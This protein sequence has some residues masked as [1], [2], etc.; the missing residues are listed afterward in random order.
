MK[1][2]LI[3]SDVDHYQHLEQDLD[4]M[5]FATKFT[6]LGMLNRCQPVSAPLTPPEV[7][8]V[9]VKLK[10]GDFWELAGY[11]TFA[12]PAASIEKVRPLL[13]AAGELLPLPYGDQV[14]GVLN[15]LNWSDCVDDETKALGQ[16]YRKYVAG[17]V[18]YTIFREPNSS[19]LLVAER[20]GDPETE[21]KACIEHRK[22][23]GLS[24]R[25]LW[26]SEA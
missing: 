17:R 1:V 21:F 22:M 13:E 24:F 5:D 9:Y 14:F 19:Y 12:L 4:H 15:V 23:T 25:E 3:Q 2:F 6:R 8:S 11:S 10:R 7:Y 26:D 18:P 16:P 20:T